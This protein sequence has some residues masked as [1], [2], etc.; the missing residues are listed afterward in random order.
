MGVNATK[1]NICKQKKV[2]AYAC[3]AI[4]KWSL[5]CCVYWYYALCAVAIESDIGDGRDKLVQSWEQELSASQSS[6][7][8]WN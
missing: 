6:G 1:L 3:T 5:L 2:H 7:K 4:V 8:L